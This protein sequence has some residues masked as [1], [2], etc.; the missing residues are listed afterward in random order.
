MKNVLA[1]RKVTCRLYSLCLC[2]MVFCFLLALPG[3]STAAR[4][5]KKA[6]P[7]EAASPKEAP[8]NDANLQAGQKRVEE[9][10]KKGDFEGAL[11]INLK[12]HEYVKG[13]LGTA[14][15][16]KGQYEKAVADT[17]VSQNTKEDLFI[18]LKGLDQLIARYNPLYEASLF[19]V[20]YLYSKRG[21]TEKASKY[22]SEFI[23]L[24]PF[25]VKRDSK[26]MK[27]KTLL[28]EMYNLEGEF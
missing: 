22:L 9:L 18:K 17:S 1:A 5:E 2:V 11:R 23:Q 21:D 25:S 8:I 14:K 28:L 26:W 19:N 27:A 7:V 20:G 24:T 10:A 15:F 4:V 3:E 16:V 12:I 6:R 13:V